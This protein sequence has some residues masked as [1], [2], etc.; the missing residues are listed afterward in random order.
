MKSRK[1]VTLKTL[2]I[3]QLKNLFTLVDAKPTWGRGK[4]SFKRATQMNPSFKCY[5]R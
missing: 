2:L 4:K 3:R 1:S 5:F